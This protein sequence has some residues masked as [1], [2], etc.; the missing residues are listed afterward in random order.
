MLIAFG[1]AAY[2]QTVNSSPL[3]STY[4]GLSKQQID[5]VKGAI[6]NSV[7]EN[8][9]L[10]NDV[11]AKFLR[12]YASD[13]SQLFTFV[14]DLN[15]KFKAFQPERQNAALGFAYNYNN[16]WTKSKSNAVATAYQS[17]A[18]NLSGNIAFNKAYN[19][20]NLLES[21][22]QYNASWMWGGKVKALDS[23]GKSQFVQLQQAIIN[24]NIAGNRSLLA[25]LY[26]QRGALAKT[27]NQYYLG[28]NGNFSLENTQDFAR[29]Q[30]VPGLLVNLGAKPWDTQQA[31]L[32]F[33][34]PDYP[35]A[36]LRLLT[37]TDSTFRLSAAS[38]PS[39]LIGI[40]H[41]IPGQD[42]IR[43][44]V[45]GNLNA[46]NRLR[47]E[48]SFK[49]LVAAIGNQMVFYSADLRY[50]REL[51]PSIAVKRAGLDHFVYFTSALEATNGFFI[52]YT[53]GRLPFDLKNNVVY[54][55]GYHF[56]LGK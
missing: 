25:R 22:F 49:T 18:L 33:N 39:M 40:D 43:Y 32:Y 56:Y 55:L 15:L 10:Y 52:S 50:Y 48:I 54:G 23:A 11:Y 6:L 16:S 45:S 7:F 4:A 2:A 24:A 47:T 51:S 34:L 35:F 37:G 8:P 17:Y 30:F 31:L 42:S 27:T 13:S 44:K 14:R 5:S 38:F 46:Y 26:A 36:I 12:N 19:T 3:Q 28:I 20:S 21:A 9:A 1:V 29:R 41:V 53:A